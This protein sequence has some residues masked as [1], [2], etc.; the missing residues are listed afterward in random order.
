LLVFGIGNPS[1]GDDA[2]GPELARRVEA[3]FSQAIEAGALEVLTDFQLQVEHALDLEGRARVFKVE[4]LTDFQLQ[5]EH[6]LDL[7]GRARVFFVDASATEPQGHSVTPVVGAR[8]ASFTT[9]LLSPAALLHT[10]GEVVGSTAPEC[11]LLAIAGHQ[12]ELGAPLSPAAQANLDAALETLAG[13]LSS[14]NPWAPPEALASPA[15]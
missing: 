15:R 7:E 4:V 2:L 11:W 13:L 8:D 14:P 3:R 12:F 5:V 9:H 6:A 10:F 1:R